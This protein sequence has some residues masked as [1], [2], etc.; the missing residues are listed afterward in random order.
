MSTP[1]DTR[2]SRLP[3]PDESELPASV[4]ALF[5]T[6]RRRTGHVPNWLAAFALHP[7][8][9]ERLTAYLFPLL[10]GNSEGAASLTSRERTILSTIVSVENGC[11][12]CHTLH[13]HEL[14]EFLSD[15][16]LA[17]RI[18]LNHREVGELSE[19]EHALA[20]LAIVL[21]HR[22][23][24]AGDDIIAPLRG[25]GLADV[26]I[27]EAVQIVAILNTTNRLSLALGL[28]PDRELF[29]Q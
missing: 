24:E 2:I 16:W 12:Y 14:G 21:T 6:T 4:R 13:V 11:A 1:T 18:A 7:G 19:R 5:D 8:H 20:E 22:P 23:G 15:H 27:H 10:E 9:F 17:N 29:H 26:D 28:V 3:V 25:L